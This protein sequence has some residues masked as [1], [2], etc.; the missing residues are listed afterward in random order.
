KPGNKSSKK[1]YLNY[2]R[3][4]SEKGAVVYFDRK[5]ILDGVYDRSVYFMVP[6]FDLDS[7]GG[8][9]PKAIEFEGTFRSSGMFP[10]F[11]EKLS[12]R[13]DYSLGFEHD[14]P[15]EGYQ[16]YEGSGRLFNKLK[17]DKMGLRGNGRIDFLSTSL[18]SEDFTFYP[19][20]VTGAGDYVEIREEEHNGIIFPQATIKKYEMKWLPKKDSMYLKNVEE[21]ILFYNET[22]SLDGAAIIS[23]KGVF[24]SGTVVSRGSEFESD[25]IKLEHDNFGARH[26]QFELKSDN[27]EKPALSGDDVRLKFDLVDNYADISPEIE[28]Q[29]A[30]AFPYAQFKT[31]ITKAR[32]D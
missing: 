20:S 18:E 2:P 25:E 19:D 1:K 26:A 3:F 24:G 7:L 15:P 6:P 12:I 11:E 9:D 32:W 29:A 17:M 30:I 23:N 14:I 8:S 13:G 10:D 27:P 28:G 16:L 21:P 31:S 22:A 4:N 5:E